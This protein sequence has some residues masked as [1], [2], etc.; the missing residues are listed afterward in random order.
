MNDARLMNELAQSCRVLACHQQN[1]DILDMLHDLEED[2]VQK[3]KDIEGGKRHADHEQSSRNESRTIR[4]VSSVAR[5]P[6]LMT[7]SRNSRQRLRTFGGQV[8]AAQ[9]IDIKYLSA[10]EDLTAINS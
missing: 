1:T 6:V 7:I 3:A 5:I 2:F 9:P 8:E 4:T 10:T